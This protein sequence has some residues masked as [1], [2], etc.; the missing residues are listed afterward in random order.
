MAEVVVATEAAAAA[1]EEDEEVD[2]GSALDCLAAA[3]LG[4][5]NAPLPV[6]EA[7][8]VTTEVLPA[9]L[10]ASVPPAMGDILRRERPNPAL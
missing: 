2:A 5:V 6:I 9:S 4:E 7:N 10:S 3:F 1:E 8:V